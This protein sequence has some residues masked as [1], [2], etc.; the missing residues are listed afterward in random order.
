MINIIVAICLLY[1]F[2]WIFVVLD[3]LKDDIVYWVKY[4]VFGK[5]YNKNTLNVVNDLLKKMDKQKSVYLTIYSFFSHIKEFPTS[6]YDTIK[7]FIQRGINGYS[8]KDLWDFDWYLCDMIPKALKQLK[9]NQNGLSLWKKGEKE[10]VSV[11]R[12]HKIIDEMIYTFEHY[13][14]FVMKKL[15]E[16]NIKRYNKGWKMFVKYFS[17]LND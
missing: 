9:G 14:D 3:D 6:I 12:W 10:S 16:K 1:I 15:S 7:Y 5:K 13:D 2:S 8:T 17:S 4:K 11:K